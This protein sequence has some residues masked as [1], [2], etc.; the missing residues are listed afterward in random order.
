M[1]NGFNS[2]CIFVLTLNLTHLVIGHYLFRVRVL[3][4]KT[5]GQCNHNRIWLNLIEFES[6]IIMLIITIC[7][8][9]LRRMGMLIVLKNCEN[10]H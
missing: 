6:E 9:E 5:G 8:S 3:R 7:K 2:H 1:T 4:G 10:C